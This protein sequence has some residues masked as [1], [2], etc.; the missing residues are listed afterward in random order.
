MILYCIT[1]ILLRFQ[2]DSQFGLE[3]VV[4]FFHVIHLVFLGLS[5]PLLLLSIVR[6]VEE[7]VLVQLGVIV[8][9]C[10]CIRPAGIVDYLYIGVFLGLLV[11]FWNSCL[12]MFLQLLHSLRWQHIPLLEFTHAQ[13]DLYCL[14][15]EGAE[16]GFTVSDFLQ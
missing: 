11:S 10:W 2:G 9:W 6:E 5:L 8:V 1:L 13:L 4:V 3:L 12:F 15:S 14:E 16:L 7:L